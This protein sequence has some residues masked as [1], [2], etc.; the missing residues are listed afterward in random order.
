MIPLDTNLYT[1]IILKNDYHLLETGKDI[2]LKILVPI[3]IFLG[4][5]KIS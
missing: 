5:H 4:K 3:Y 1:S 2:Y